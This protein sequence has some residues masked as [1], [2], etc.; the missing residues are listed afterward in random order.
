MVQS[1]SLLTGDV[2]FLQA[3]RLWKLGFEHATAL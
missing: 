1:G 3:F 2:K